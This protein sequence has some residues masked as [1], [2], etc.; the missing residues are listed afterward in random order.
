MG[1]ETGVNAMM[2]CRWE[3]GRWMSE[4]RDSCDEVER[5]SIRGV[6]WTLVAGRWL[7][8]MRGG[9]RARMRMLSSADVGLS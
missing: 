2:T 4:D 7:L 8:E 9:G 5:K 3:R 1:A 6:E